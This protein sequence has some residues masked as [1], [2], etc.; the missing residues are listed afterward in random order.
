MGLW[1]TKDNPPQPIRAIKMTAS[2]I[3]VQNQ[4]QYLFQAPTI[5]AH[6]FF[7]WTNGQQGSQRAINLLRRWKPWPCCVLL[8]YRALGRLRWKRKVE[9]TSWVQLAGCDAGDP[10]CFPAIAQKHQIDYRVPFRTCRAKRGD[11]LSQHSLIGC[12]FSLEYVCTIFTDTMNVKIYAHVFFDNI[13]ESNMEGESVWRLDFDP[14][15]LLFPTLVSSL[16]LF[17]YYFSGF[18]RAIHIRV[19][20]F[21]APVHSEGRR[22]SPPGCRSLQWSLSWHIGGR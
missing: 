16:S 15:I 14:P 19:P 5:I 17:H 10:E 7:F 11:V 6:C 1:M 13:Q 12:V 4:S 9:L 3:Q 22:S 21:Y 20:G 2:K 8:S 18:W